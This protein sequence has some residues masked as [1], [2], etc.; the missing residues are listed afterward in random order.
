MDTRVQGLRE[1][2]MQQKP[3]LC[4]ERAR[5]YTR[6]WQ[7]TE[8][9]PVAI[10][11][12][13]ALKEILENQH[14]FIEK[15]ELIVGNQAGI[16]NAAPIFPEY[17]M[18][19]LLEELPRMND[20][21]LDKFEVSEEAAQEL[22]EL[23]P[24]WKGKT[25]FDKCKE[26]LS[27]VMPEQYQEVWDAAHGNFN[28]TVTNSGRMTTGDGH[29][30][31]NFEDT[32][33]RGLRSVIDEAKGYI[34]KCDEDRGKSENV[35]KKI[36][37]K[38]AV[39]SME[40]AVTFANRYADEAQRMAD[41]GI[42]DAVEKQE[43]LEIARICRKVPEF[44]AETFHEALQS[45]WMIHLILQIESNG[46]SM[47]FGRFDQYM[48]P[49]YEKDVQAGRL[50][51]E[52][53]LSM[54]QCF[55]LKCNQIKKIRAMSHTRTM[56][57]YPMFQTLTIGGQKRDGSDAVNDMS[58]LVLE[59]TGTVKMQEPT[60]IA[61]L[62]PGTP[63]EFAMQCCKTVV[64]HGGGQPG[65][66]NDQVT[67]PMLM[68]TGVTLEDARDWAVDGCCEPIVPGKHNT[69]N[70][71]CCHINLLKVLEMALDG[72][73]NR[74][75]GTCVLPEEKTLAEM[76]S[77]EEVEK[78][79]RRQLEFYVSMIPMFD[80]VT[81]RA[82]AELTPC[83]FLSSVLDY[84]LEIGKDVEEGGGP[85]YNNTLSICHGA[86][87]VGNALY[88]LKEK[89]F[90]EKVCTPGEMYE[91][92]RANWEGE[93]NALLRRKML[94]A[95]KYG[96]DEDSVDLVVRQSLDWYFN[97][98]RSY[99]P[100]RGG[101]YCPSPQTLSANAYKG[102][103]IG[104]TPDGRY[105]GS[106]MADNVSPEAGTDLSGATAALKSV[107]KVDHILAT[108]GTILNIKLHPTAV[109]G[110]ERLQ[111]FVSLIQT[112]FNLQGFQV[113]FNIVAAETLRAAQE[114]PDEYK[115]LVVKVAGYSAL[116]VN[117]DPHLQDQIIA[118]TEHQI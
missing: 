89:V 116:F 52:Q 100:A 101:T 65:L 46:H 9:K 71:G 109:S 51:R 31:A 98:I 23:A 104:A 54:L 35:K 50:T 58:Y 53:A 40:A 43:L 22:S 86:I 66:F 57:G 13:L 5:Y 36:F 61:R 110:E 77:Y 26:E 60:T 107:A 59:A 114:E 7:Q 15:G 117:L 69:I 102:E 78:A 83:P 81:S 62:H 68:S 33:R 93:K 63:N 74:H 18:E 95:E 16:P 44:G 80:E 11:R 111:K 92:L 56:H 32:I 97:E 112:Y 118:R 79:Y 67:I 17:G 73:R 113:Q 24:Y 12:A 37:L 19:W 25:H 76:T 49:Y 8:G 39:I 106:V 70:G 105:A 14:V 42:M 2:V 115:G 99:T 28:G 96:N 10:R 30:I 75:T 55:F 87:N 6:S 88:A 47:S 94:D 90:E 3:A 48:Q 91:A 21:L 72:G 84:R 1:L 20:R 29:V 4:S 82:H 108:D 64:T 103:E 45:Y 38:S 41:E 85:N 34:A 27:L